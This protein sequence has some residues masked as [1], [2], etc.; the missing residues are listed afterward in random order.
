M[1]RVKSEWHF[2]IVCEVAACL[3]SLQKKD[4]RITSEIMKIPVR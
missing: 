3:G 1:G 4:L 2:S